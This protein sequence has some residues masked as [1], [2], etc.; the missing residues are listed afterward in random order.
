MS[1]PS[2]L[3]SLLTLL[4]MSSSILIIFTC[5]KPQSPS[6]LLHRY[7]Y[8]TNITKQPFSNFPKTQD[9]AVP[10]PGN[11]V[12]P[13]HSIHEFPSKHRVLL[14]HLHH[15]FHWK[16]GSGVNALFVSGF[17]ISSLQMMKCLF[18]QNSAWMSISHLF[19][20]Q[21]IRVMFKVLMVMLSSFTIIY[22]L[23]TTTQE[24]TKSTMVW[25]VCLSIVMPSLVEVM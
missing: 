11:N 4:N 6:N 10:F 13:Q 17:K 16:T 7:S 24:E 18:V 9:L 22:T 14:L 1:P 20:S 8:T 12:H 23:I 25:G 3:L 5:T 19:A 2:L 21:A 15:H